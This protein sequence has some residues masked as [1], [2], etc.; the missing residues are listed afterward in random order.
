[1]SMVEVRHR[2]SEALQKP[3]LHETAKHE[4][5]LWIFGS[6]AAEKKEETNASSLSGDEDKLGVLQAEWF[7]HW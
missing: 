4:S 1:M 3:S 6:R 7:A 2:A 5:R